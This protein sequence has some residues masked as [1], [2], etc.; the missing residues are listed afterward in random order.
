MY[1]ALFYY[2]Y[3]YLKNIYHKYY[4]NIF[5]LSFNNHNLNDFYIIPVF[6]KVNQN[7]EHICHPI[8]HHSQSY[9]F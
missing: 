7:L 6:Q 5:Y 8:W 1:V 3:F 9:P 4:N 2:D